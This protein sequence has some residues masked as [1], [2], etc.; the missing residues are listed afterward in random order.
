MISPP[1]MPRATPH[2]SASAAILA[3]LV[4]AVAIP[5]LTFLFRFNL[6]ADGAIFSYS[7]AAADGWRFHWVNIAN[8]IAVFLIAHLPA[9]AI[10]LSTGEP[11]LAIGIYTALF[12][13]AP[14]AGLVLTIRLDTAPS[15]AF[16]VAASLGTVLFLPFVVPFPSELVFTHALFFPALALAMSERGGRSRF[17]GLIV[18]MTGLANSHE[19]GA[20]CAICVLA[21]TLFAGPGRGAVLRALVAFTVA[22]AVWLTLR[23]SLPPGDYVSGVLALA[24]WRM[25]QV[26]SVL[27]RAMNWALL[28]GAVGLLSG[29]V[30]HAWLGRAGV[31]TAGLAVSA[32]LMAAWFLLDPPAH[33]VDRYNMRLVLLVGDGLLAGM[34]TLFVAR[35]GGRAGWLFRFEPA[36]TGPVVARLAVTAGAAVV[37][38]LVL[39]AGETVRFAGAWETYLTRV[40]R[41]ATGEDIVTDYA[42][43]PSFASSA[44]IADGRD[45]VAWNSTTPY[46]SVLLAPQFLPRRLVVDPTTGYWWMDCATARASRDRELGLP[47]RARALIAAY[48]CKHRP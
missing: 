3:G 11:D 9:Q 14:L 8:R 47:R 1:V 28:A 32:G 46:L 13:S 12:Y 25:I 2:P 18:L 31:W 15:R 24:A 20:V 35:Q 37:P 39:H 17:A 36:W 33:A 6:F 4:V 48:A 30:L 44:R 45:N 40:E 29:L 38:L 10:G 19:G 21:A 22:A 42:G 5:V 41:I 27:S 7:V 34:A 16:A 23:L 43:D 26:E